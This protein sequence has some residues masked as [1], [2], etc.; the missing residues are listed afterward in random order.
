MI[1]IIIMLMLI[2]SITLAKRGGRK[3][4]NKSNKEKA[5]AVLNSLQL[6][7]ES[8]P[9][10]YIS[11]ETYIQH[12]LGAGDGR[13][14]FLSL[15][16]IPGVKFKV[17]IVRVFEDGNFVVTHS[18]YDFFGPK[19]GF[20]IFRFKD[21]KMVEHLDNLQEIVTKTQSGRSQVDG[22]TE[23]ADLDKT[24]ENKK[25]VEGFVNDV[26]LGENPG[27]ITN[28]ISTE[29]YYQH[30]PGVADGLE[31]LGSALRELAEAGM[32]MIYSKN[33]R[34]LGE[35]NFV[36]AQS[37]GTFMKKHVA[38]YDLFRVEDGK[39]VEHWDTIE[40]IPARENWKNENSKF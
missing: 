37:E 3:M 26:L 21:G 11:D 33:H 27:R 14:G 9:L 2:G 5:V 23:I 29:E 38:F 24:E 18:I 35:G 7:E 8:V 20:D 25:L 13:E 36:L 1:T 19:V 40:E 32:P 30:N 28:Y 31:G 4:E 39:I 6:R 10:K 22:P 17:N 15:F 16:D 12:N 34:I